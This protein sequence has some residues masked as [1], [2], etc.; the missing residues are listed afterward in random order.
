MNL[1]QRVKDTCWIELR[2][3]SFCFETYLLDNWKDNTLIDEFIFK[4]FE[5]CRVNNIALVYKDFEN[6]AVEV[7]QQIKEML[8][9]G[10]DTYRFLAKIPIQEK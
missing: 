8:C 1:I 6:E 10:G 4:P 2:F 5:T 9:I 7:V 3:D